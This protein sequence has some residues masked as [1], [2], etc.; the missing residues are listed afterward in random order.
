LTPN[1]EIENAGKNSEPFVA[2]LIIGKPAEIITIT[3][4]T[5]ERRNKWPLVG[6]RTLTISLIRT[7]VASAA[8][9]LDIGLVE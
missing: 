4:S 3:T 9:I 2:D 1:S 7:T 5:N 8:A 6:N